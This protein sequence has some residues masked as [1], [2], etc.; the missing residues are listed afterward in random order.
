MI[1]IKIFFKFRFYKITYIK[2]KH[3][4]YIRGRM[5]LRVI[6]NTNQKESV[7]NE[8]KSKRTREDVSKGMQQH[9]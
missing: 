2:R 7:S 1:T 3:I 5:K 9:G 6:G 8:R 4:G